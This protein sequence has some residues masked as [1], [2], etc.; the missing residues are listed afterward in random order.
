MT[1]TFDVTETGDYDLVLHMAKSSEYGTN[2][3][4]RSFTLP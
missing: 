3:V 2:Q 4:L 1:V